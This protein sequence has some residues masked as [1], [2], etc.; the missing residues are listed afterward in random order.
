MFLYDLHYVTITETELLIILV[1]P[2]KYN[3][4]FKAAFFTVNIIPYH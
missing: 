3:H 4:L 1:H 2:D